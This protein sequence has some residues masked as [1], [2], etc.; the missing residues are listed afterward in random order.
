MPAEDYWTKSGNSA[1]LITD[2][3]TSNKVG[4]ISV[5]VLPPNLVCVLELSF[6]LS[7]S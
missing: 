1:L 7:A 4:K 3:T 5:P 2:N 6:I